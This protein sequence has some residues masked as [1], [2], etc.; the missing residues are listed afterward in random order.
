MREAKRRWADCAQTYTEPKPISG[1]FRDTGTPD[2]AALDKVLGSG[3]GQAEHVAQYLRAAQGQP[4][5]LHALAP[6]PIRLR[7]THGSAI[8]KI[9]SR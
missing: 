4:E 2:S 6:S 5:P 9:A 7:S 1:I 8:P 3:A